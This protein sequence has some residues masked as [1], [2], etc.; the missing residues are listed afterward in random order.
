MSK[1]IA[2]ISLTVIIVGFLCFGAY[3]VFIR[4]SGISAEGDSRNNE[5][6]FLS[7]RGK[8]IVDPRGDEVFLR[9]VN[10]GGFLS[11][12]GMGLPTEADLT[13]DQLRE[14][15]EKRMGRESTDFLFDEYSKNIIQKQDF[16]NAKE[17]GV[18]FIRLMFDYRCV[19]T[20]KIDEAVGW[21]KEAGIY[22]I[23]DMQAAPGAQNTFAH[24]NHDGAARLWTDRANQDEMVRLWEVLAGRFKDEPAVA[25]YEIV[26]E[27]CVADNEK[28][29]SL[30]KRMIEAIREIDRRHIILLDDNGNLDFSVF[31]ENDFGSN[32]VYVF[33]VYSEG[34]LMRIPEYQA[35]GE[36]RQVP[37]MCNEY[38]DMALI[39]F[40]EAEGIPHAPMHYKLNRDNP[41]TPFYYL[42]PNN[43]YSIWI[44]DIVQRSSDGS[45]LSRR[46]TGLI[47]ESSLSQDLK[48]TLLAIL[49]EK[50]T[51]GEADIKL[52][53]RDAYTQASGIVA[54]IRN[55]KSALALDAIAETFQEKSRAEKNAL[56]ESLRTEY[57]ERGMM[58][59]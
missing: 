23:L 4:N 15:L 29:A 25:G 21:A 16:V 11:Y 52:L 8:V 53:G 54:E 43:L 58:G 14:E 36:E 40:F 5:L 50:G 59:F 49:R 13:E 28:L 47:G 6:P 2:L 3:H 34:V 39:A 45:V 51:I 38:G 10:F 26:N 12:G 48:D 44:H 32:L 9:G 30:Y 27:P 18:N 1:K 31:K 57:W 22:V 20:G 46:I 24:A 7:V 56:M 55:I 37:V 17:A 42:P 33:H 19:E 41:D 35:F